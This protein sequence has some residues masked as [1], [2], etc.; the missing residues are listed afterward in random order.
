MFYRLY[1]LFFPLDIL[2]CDKITV[3]SLI[4]SL[5]RS[6]CT[7]S[8]EPRSYTSRL[9]IAI[10]KCPICMFLH[11]WRKMVSD[12]ERFTQLHWNNLMFY[13]SFSGKTSLQQVRSN[14]HAQTQRNTT[15]GLL[16]CSVRVK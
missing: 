16:T 3:H 10:W 2:N 15:G 11:Y 8:K 9:P 1:L 6:S 4:H 14:D 7:G 13:F 5:Y 12:F